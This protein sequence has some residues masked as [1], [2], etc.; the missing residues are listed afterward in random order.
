VRHVADLL[1]ASSVPRS[2]CA[3]SPPSLIG[4]H[5]EARARGLAD[6]A[7]RR[8]RRSSI[9]EVDDR[10]TATSWT[11][12]DP[13]ARHPAGVGRGQP[14]SVV[15]VGVASASPFGRTLVDGAWIDG[16]WLDGAWLDGTW[17]ECTASWS[18]SIERDDAHGQTE[19]D[20][21]GN[22]VSA[23][24]RSAIG[25]LFLPERWHSSGALAVR[26]S[27]GGGVL[28][29]RIHGVGRRQFFRTRAIA[30]AG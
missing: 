18:V 1:A 30:L 13:T 20:A 21:L 24:D 10:A 14:S 22:A 23:H 12:R 2:A 27:A 4:Q 15:E 29:A 25:S 9:G 8:G 7:A 6:P 16:A 5:H 26:K 17:L 11:A 3:A 28:R 19:W